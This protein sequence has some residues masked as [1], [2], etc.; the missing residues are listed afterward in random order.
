MSTSVLVNDT[1][2]IKV[3]F[4]DTNPLTG[5]QVPVTP[6]AVVITIKKSDETV[7]ITQNITTSGKISDS[8][9]YYDFTP[10]LADTYK[11]TF[12]GN[13]TGGTSITVNQQLYVSTSV[14]EYKPTITLK[15]D[16]TIIF[17]PDVSPLYLDP[18]ELKPYF[19]EASLI[20]IGELI[21]SH[22]LEVK[23][24]YSLS[25]DV[26]GSSL[27]Y[28]ALEYIKAATACELSRTYS[29]GGDDDVSVQLGDLTVTTRN[30]PRSEITRGNATTWCQIAAALRKEMLAGKTG[31]KGMVPKG[32]PSES[33]GTSGK[34]ID[35]ETGKV[36]YLSDRELYG[37]GKKILPKEDPMPKRG[38]RSYD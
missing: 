2:K 12:V 38:I 22:S 26:T 34:N 24:I 9:Y 6:V 10:T 1:V 23:Q 28:T 37:P 21:Y 7:L 16:E 32:L 30:L 27:S 31:P 5:A 18:E 35:P 25:D 13:L 19:P 14:D 4:V 33:I 8:E 11:I 29:Y 20:E 15:A 3:K 17:A 36:Y